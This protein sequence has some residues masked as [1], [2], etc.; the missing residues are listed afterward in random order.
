VRAQDLGSLKIKIVNENGETLR[1]TE[2]VLLETKNSA[3]SLFLGSLEY[4]VASPLDVQ[5]VVEAMGEKIP[6]ITSLS[7]R[8]ITLE[9]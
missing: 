1:E 9:P 7:S 6:E 8:R 5:L 2:G 4:F 3:Y